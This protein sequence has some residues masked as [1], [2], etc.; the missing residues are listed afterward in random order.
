MSHEG[1]AFR[2]SRAACQPY[3]DRATVGDLRA[4]PRANGF[5]P[6]RTGI[7]ISSNR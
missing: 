5:A 3:A 4:R 1:S 6:G 7:V 2:S